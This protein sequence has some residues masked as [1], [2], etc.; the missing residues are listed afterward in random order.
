MPTQPSPSTSATAPAADP[1][2]KV[3]GDADPAL[4]YHISQG[5][6]G[7]SDAFTGALSRDAGENVGSYNITQG[8]LAL[9]AHYDLSFVGAH[10]VISKRGVEVTADPQTKVYGDADPALTYHIS[11]GTLGFSDAFSGAL[12]RDAG[13]NI[14]SYPTTPGP[15]P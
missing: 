8:S 5:S 6:L 10:L 12:T 11:N 9:T 2:T 7:F 3:Y 13:E 15:L 14:G 4:T 1:Q